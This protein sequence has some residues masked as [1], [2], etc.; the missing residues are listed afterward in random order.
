MSRMCKTSF[1][2]YLGTAV[3][4]AA[5]L[6]PSIGA[7][8]PS[9]TVMQAARELEGTTYVVP[10]NQSSAGTVNGCGFE[11][12][13]MAFDTAYKRGAPIVING[14][15]AASKLDA[16]GIYFTYKLGTFNLTDNG[17]QPEAPHYAW[18]KLGDVMVKPERT[19]RGESEGYKLYLSK[20]PEDAS[21]AFD[22]VIAQ[23]PVSVGFNRKEGGLDVVVPLDL[24]VRDTKM[25]SQVVRV[26]DRKLGEGF[27]QCL[28][29]LLASFKR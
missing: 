21:G 9:S 29:Q 2:F 3:G 28:R 10:M 5:I 19:I 1:R 12:K 18:I 14:S 24:S 11:F 25:E 27:S 23:G 22:A 15:F 8:Q 4:L 6:G 17:L 16:E 20:L 13:A 26:R 7:S